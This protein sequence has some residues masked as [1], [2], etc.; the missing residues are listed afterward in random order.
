MAGYPDLATSE[1][2]VKTMAEAGAAMVEIQIPFSDPVAD[3]PVIMQANETA[4]RQG[5]TPD[6]CF[7]LMARIKPSV[8][9]PLLFMTYY[10]IVLRFGVEE[11]CRRAA[12]VGAYGLIVPDIPYHEEPYDH[13]LAA[14]QAHHLH[15]IQVVSPLTPERRL[16]HI[17]AVAS[18]FIYCVSHTGLTGDRH[19]QHKEFIEY[20]NRVR[21]FTDLPLAVGFGISTRE[22]VTALT[23]LAD[24]VVMGSQVIRLLDANG[25][26]PLE[27]IGKFLRT[28]T[29]D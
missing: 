28:I 21:R 12:A 13:F 1:A 19:S 25:E 17:A 11:F 4:L 24:I 27:T 14:C 7:G 2:L 20:L 9:I 6:L 26:D 16:E 23:G 10:N 22:Q 8:T 5:M 29:A 18:G 3:G 15:P